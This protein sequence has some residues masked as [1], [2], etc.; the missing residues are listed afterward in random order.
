MDFEG[1]TG[2]RISDILKLQ[3]AQLTADG[4]SAPA[5]ARQ[6]PALGVD[7]RA[8][9]DRR[10]VDHP[11][12]RQRL[13]GLA[14]LPQI[15]AGDEQTYNAFDTTWQAL[16]R[17][18]NALLAECEI[19]LASTTCTSTTCAPRRTTTLRKRASRGTSSSATRA[20]VAKHY[21]RREQKVRPLR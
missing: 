11:T 1:I 15:A 8:P 6:A 2:W 5:E 7:R 20:S 4:S 18:T 9:P 12:R 21:R 14:S 13:P 3:R 17:R 16:K 10:R 19:P